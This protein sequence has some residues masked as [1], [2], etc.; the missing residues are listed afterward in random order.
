MSDGDLNQALEKLDGVV[1]PVT[2]TSLEPT[3]EAEKS[4]DEEERFFATDRHARDMADRDVARNQRK[5]YAKSVF[6]LV[7]GWIT[8]IYVLLLLQVFGTAITPAYK[9]LGEGV[10]IA[11][12]SST[13]VNLIGTLIIVLKYIFR[14]PGS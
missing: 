2:P 12:I 10:L 3:K 6:W 5:V 11:L 13:T 9:P 14:T 8:A 4:L 1:V 7:C